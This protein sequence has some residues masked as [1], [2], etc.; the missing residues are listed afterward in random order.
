MKRNFWPYGIVITF[1]VFFSGTVG[2]LVMACLQK[3]DLVSKTYYE[4]ELRYQ[5][6]LDSL[7]RAAQSGAS[8][9][10]D[11]AGRNIAIALPP[12]KSGASPAGS[13]ELYRPSEAS[14]DREMPLQLDG[15]GRQVID[16]SG[17]QPGLWKVRVNWSEGGTEYQLERSL[18]NGPATRAAH[19]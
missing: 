12:S 2:L 8:L 11:A 1:V 9:T 17:L 5:S 3:E 13:V 6:R 18:T 4:Q 14:L 15:S 7:K 19:S 16:A 10:Y